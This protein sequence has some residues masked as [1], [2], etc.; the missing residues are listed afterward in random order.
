MVDHV[1]N[2]EKPSLPFQTPMQHQMGRI[3]TREILEMF[4]REDLRSLLCLFELVEEDETHCRYNVSEQVNPG[5]TRLKELVHDKDADKAYCCCKG[6]EFWGFE[7]LEKSFDDICGKLTRLVSSR[8]HVE[9]EPN[10]DVGTSYPQMR[11][12]DPHRVKAKGHA[13]RAKGEKEKAVQ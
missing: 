10:G 13:K 6:F 1:D 8:A 7:L 4:E 3:Y 12:K 9:E 11:I 2:N 5:V